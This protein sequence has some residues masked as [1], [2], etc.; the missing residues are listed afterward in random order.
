MPLPK[1]VAVDFTAPAA[2]ETR[3]KALAA[4]LAQGG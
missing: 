1:V 3:A 2:G 4:V